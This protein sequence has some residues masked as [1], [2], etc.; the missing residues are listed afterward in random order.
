VEELTAVAQ[1]GGVTD[2]TYTLALLVAA[3]IETLSAVGELKA[4]PFHWQ[5]MLIAAGETE[6]GAC[7]LAFTVA[8]TSGVLVFPCA[9]V[10]VAGVEALI[11]VQP[12]GSLRLTV[13][14]SVEP[15]DAKV[16]VA[17]PANVA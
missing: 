5:T 9:K 17:A 14:A 4:V 11:P 15:A 16:P 7:W 6:S 13:T 12:A 3:E 10:T 2:A 8:V 1:E